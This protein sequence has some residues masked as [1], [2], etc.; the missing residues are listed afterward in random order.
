V[1]ALCA[2]LEPEYI[3]KTAVYAR[4]KGYMKD[5][6]ALLCAVLSNKG[7]LGRGYLSLIFPLIIDNGKM[8]R[9]FVQIMRSGVVG[10]KSLGTLPKRLVRDWLTNRPHDD[11]F[12][13]SVGNDPSLSDIIKMVHPKTL[14]GNVSPVWAKERSLLYR[15]LIGKDVHPAE[16][17]GLAGAYEK[18][19][20]LVSMDEYETPAEIPNVPFQMLTALNLGTEEWT[21]IA[22]NAGWQMTRMNI[23]TFLRHGVFES[24][25]M[26]KLIADR[27]RD[28][29]QVRRSRCF[30]YQLLTAYNS[31]STETPH[32]VREALQD[33]MEVAVENV[34]AI[35]GQVHVYVDVSG[36]MSCPITGYRDGSTS[37]TTCVDV[38]G[39]IAAAILRHNPSALIVP[40]SNGT[41]HCHVNPRDSVMTTAKTLANM[42]G[43]GTN[44][45]A[46][47]ATSNA[48]GL[49]ADLVVYVSD[50]ESWIDTERSGMWS[51]GSSGT[52]T[53]KEWEV[54]KQ[55]NPHADMVCI[56]L[57]PN[58]TTQA[59]ETGRGDILNIG[60][61][62]DTVFKTLA[63]FAHGD[64][65]HW[66]EEIESIV[67]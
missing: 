22:R 48:Q 50:S 14:M 43:G 24:E 36:S 17:P 52:K 8:L 46:P 25:E 44:C 42:C 34:P 20:A 39:L 27:L 11:L 13:A 9:N 40:F 10:R 49:N 56:D 65:L 57:V 37:A 12:W 66:S 30:P 31:V 29:E 54:F 63:S 51:C 15:Y 53:M 45:S 28:P 4:T 64:S 3:A 23:N 62:S 19:K 6:P 60:G 47:L 58:S 33:A 2:E 1:L 21:Q 67:L 26:V 38:A 16:L 61:F 7:E 18:Y 41:E 32:D 35:P 5:M 59:N 55:R